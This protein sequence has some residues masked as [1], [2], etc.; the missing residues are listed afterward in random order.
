MIKPDIAHILEKHAQAGRDALIP[1]LQEVQEAAGYLSPEAVIEVGR[2]LKLPASKVYGVATFY[3]QFRFQ[4]KGKYHFMVCRGTACHVKGSAKILDTL[5]KH[6]K[7]E[8]GKTSRDQLF[9]LE[10]VAC[11]GA[12]ALSP[13]I[14]LN[15]EFHA[16]VSPAKVVKLLDTCRSRENHKP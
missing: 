10:V 14:C 5:I 7:I 9:S 11:M 2:R 15:N 4:P 1:I 12:C 6:L 13:V 3:N 16:K 8:P